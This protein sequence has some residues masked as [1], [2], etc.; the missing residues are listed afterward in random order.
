MYKAF[1]AHNGGIRRSRGSDDMIQQWEIG[2]ASDYIIQLANE[3]EIMLK[4]GHIKHFIA[5]TTDSLSDTHRV[6]NEEF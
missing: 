5:V 1:I 2:N 6:E 3:V 4:Q